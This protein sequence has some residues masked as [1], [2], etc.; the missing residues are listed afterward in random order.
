M[1]VNMTQN[2]TVQLRSEEGDLLGGQVV[3]PIDITEQQLESLCATLLNVR[4][5]LFFDVLR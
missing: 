3:V 5:S 2:V 4:S 1:D